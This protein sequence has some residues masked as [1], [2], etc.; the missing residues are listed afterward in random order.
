MPERIP[1]KIQIPTSTLNL[2]THNIQNN[3]IE[4]K[5]DRDLHLSMQNQTK[6]FTIEMERII[7]NLNR[8]VHRLER[9]NRD[10][11]NIKERS[12]GII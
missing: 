8:N 7:T 4:I 12:R 11:I 10:K 9:N 6:M 1:I 2:K 3:T 5:R